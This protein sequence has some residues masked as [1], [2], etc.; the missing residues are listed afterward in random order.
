MTFEVKHGQKVYIMKAPSPQRAL[1]DYRREA[2][3]YLIEHEE[4]EPEVV[5]IDE[6]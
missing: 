3:D 2:E 1:E 4:D 5:L 6:Y